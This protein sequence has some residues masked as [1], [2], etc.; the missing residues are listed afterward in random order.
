MY[1]WIRTISVSNERFFEMSDG[2]KKLS[3]EGTLTGVMSDDKD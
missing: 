2:I 1:T 3:N